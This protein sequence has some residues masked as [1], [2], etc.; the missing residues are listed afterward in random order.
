MLSKAVYHE[1]V[2]VGSHVHTDKE[3]VKEM[4]AGERRKMF[5]LI[6]DSIEA[7]S[8]DRILNIGCGCGGLANE[9][10]ERGYDVT[11]VTKGWQKSFMAYDVIVATHLHSFSDIKHMC[12]LA[13]KRVY[14]ASSADF[15]VRIFEDHHG[16]KQDIYDNLSQV[17]NMLYTYGINPNVK[18]IEP[19][20]CE[21]VSLIYWDV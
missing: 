20:G 1:N 13:K 15:G 9:L 14:I 4:T 17:F 6:A 21:A 7:E 16:D 19:E 8:E 18:I 3:A 2:S 5:G 11:M 12:R 10:R